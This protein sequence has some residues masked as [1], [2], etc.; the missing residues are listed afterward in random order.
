MHSILVN[1]Y[2]DSNPHAVH[3]DDS[4]RQ[5]VQFLLKQNLSGAP[6]VNQDNILVGFVSEQDCIKEILNDAF[7][8]EESPKVSA[9]M[10]AKVST[11]KPETSIIELAERMASAA[12]RNVP[13]V[14]N[15][16]LVGLISRNTILNAILEN[17][18]DCYLHH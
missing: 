5:V 14:K 13:V 4:V 12:P 18:E 9:V 11:V 8:C 2:M 17:E 10:H 3:H 1:D 15:G 16:K 7:H 6:V